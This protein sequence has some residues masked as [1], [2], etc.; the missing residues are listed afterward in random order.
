MIKYFLYH[1]KFQQQNQVL[2]LSL[3]TEFSRFST[4][5]LKNVRRGTKAPVSFIQKGCLQTIIQSKA[6]SQIQFSM[7]N[8]N[9]TIGN[10]KFGNTQVQSSKKFIKEEFSDAM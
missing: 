8:N 2:N 7:N 4:K 6:G 10:P 9:G 5:Y 1:K 3:S